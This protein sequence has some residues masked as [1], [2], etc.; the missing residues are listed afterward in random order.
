MPRGKK[1]KAEEIIPPLREA[2]VLISQVKTQELA[3]KQIDVSTLVRWRKEYGVV[4]Y[5]LM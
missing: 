1:Y 5:Y 2:E 3:A 4:N